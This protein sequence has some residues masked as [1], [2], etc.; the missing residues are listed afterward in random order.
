M[1]VLTDV[2]VVEL[3]RSAAG[4]F[5]GRLCADAGAKVVLVEPPEGHPLRAEGPFRGDAPD[6]ET[7]AAHL[8]INAGKRSVTLDLASESG[9]LLMLL[10]GADVFLTDVLAKALDP[11]GLSWA[12]LH[13]RWPSLLVTR[14]TPF[15]DSGPCRDYEGT[16]LTALASG[17]QLK[18][19]GDPDKPPLS[20]FGAQAEYQA[21]LSAFAGTLANLL[22][23]DA[24]GEGAY[25]DLSV[26]DVVATNL[27]HRAPALN[28]G[29]EAHRVG[30]TVSATYGVYPCADGWVYVTAFAP[31][32]W[33]RLKA[34]ASLPELD[35]ERFSTQAD[36]LAH[37]DELQAVLTGWTLTK[38]TVELHELALRGYP[39]T[40]S[41]T[42]ETLLRS[43]QWRNRSVA[44]EIEHAAA[45]RIALIG[46]PWYEPDGIDVKPAPL[47]GEA[48][49]ELLGLRAG[50]RG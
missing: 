25:L 27:E 13:T 31:A 37:N 24:S 28:L 11:P 49:E 4:G 22:L 33:E 50:S 23:R 30:L 44:R 9:L 38:T 45:G 26:Q 47:L 16:N 40:T 15:G 43:E 14:I 21:G 48:N 29:L 12:G 2:R 36:R 34:I 39:F 35:E 1:D 3:T 18:I 46:A 5:A 6:R 20:N 41:E 8:H 7:S 32:L 10:D 19:T 17:G 42:Q